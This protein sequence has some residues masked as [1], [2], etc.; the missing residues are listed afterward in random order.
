L[1][2]YDAAKDISHSSTVRCFVARRTSLPKQP[3]AAFVGVKSSGALSALLR[4][5]SQNSHADWAA[6]FNDANS[7]VMLFDGVVRDG[8]YVFCSQ[9]NHAMKF[10]GNYYFKHGPDPLTGSAVKFAVG[11]NDYGLWA[12]GLH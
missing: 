3:L 8:K 1:K 9:L 10:H 6:E 11:V 7:N 5:G 2:A 4:N 12:Y